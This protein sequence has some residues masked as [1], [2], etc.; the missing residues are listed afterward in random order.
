MKTKVNSVTLIKV[1]SSQFFRVDFDVLNISNLLTSKGVKVDLMDLNLIFQKKLYSKNGFDEILQNKNLTEQEFLNFKARVNFSNHAHMKRFPETKI[2][3]GSLEQSNKY[4]SKYQNSIFYDVFK[5]FIIPNNDLIIFLATTP[6]EI[7]NAIIIKNILKQRNIIEKT[8]LI[9]SF[10]GDVNC[11]TNTINHFDYVLNKFYENTIFEKI[12]FIKNDECKNLIN[13][14]NYLLRSKVMPLRLSNSCYYGKCNFCDKPSIKEKIVIKDVDNVV[15]QMNNYHEQFNT[16]IFKFQDDALPPSAIFDLSSKI[17]NK[18]HKWF[19][20]IR[21]EKV[22]SNKQNIRLL[23]KAGCIRLFAGLET[24]SEELLKKMNKNIDLEI[25]EKIIKNCHEEGIKVSLS[26]LFDFPTESLC[27]IKKTIK[28]IEKNIFFIDTVEV[29]YFV[30]TK[31][32]YVYKNKEEFNINILDESDYFIKFEENDP[33][34]LEKQTL[35]QDFLLFLK[36]KNKIKSEWHYN[37][38]L[39]ND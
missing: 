7:N 26:V 24:A 29:N 3:L 32:S 15:S 37:Y 20:N 6:N 8:M 12:D 23:K 30:L 17:I 39:F 9:I 28:F 19:G 34:R 4:I 10:T 35:I 31:N 1:P 25:V 11:F 21:F 18:S 2:S 5:D 27:D 38:E 22:Y 13:F 14:D 33:S 36:N 16:K